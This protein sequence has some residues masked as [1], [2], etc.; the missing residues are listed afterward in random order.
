[1]HAIP[2][3]TMKLG[4]FVGDFE[5]SVH[6]TSAV[7]VAVKQYKAGDS[8]PAHCHR[9]AREL[10]VIVSGSVRM[11]G[12]E[13]SAGTIVVIEPGEATDFAALTDAVT[14]VVKIPGAKDDKFPV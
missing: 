5:P 12:T 1:M 7:E 11:N 14:A 6:R 8:E 13:Y 9:V 3:S 4:W 10:T 2:L